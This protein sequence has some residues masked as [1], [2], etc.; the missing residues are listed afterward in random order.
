MVSGTSLYHVSVRIGVLSHPRWQS[1]C[2]DCAGGIDSVI[3]LLQGQLSKSVMERVCEPGKGLFPQPSEITFTCSCPDYA[4][5]CKHVAAVL[6]GV[7]A[8]LDQQPEL[9]FTLR[10]VDQTELVGNVDGGLLAKTGPDVRTVLA[11]D[12]LSALCGLDMADD[13]PPSTTSATN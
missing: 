8:R 3:E 11:D 10:A 9:L 6:Y 4:F 12:D 1:I 2:R 13:T 7:G 5:M